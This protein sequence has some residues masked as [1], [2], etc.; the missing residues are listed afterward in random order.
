MGKVKQSRA[1]E[2]S[3]AASP[4]TGDGPEAILREHN[5]A[6][7]LASVAVAFN[8]MW[9]SAY[10]F[11]GR[12][13]WIAQHVGAAIGYTEEGFRSVLQDWTGELIR[14]KDFDV[15]EGSELREF[16]ALLEV[17]VKKT[18][19]YAPS[20]AILYEPGFYL[21]CFR[22]HL[23]LGVK[24]RRVMADEVMPKLVRGEPILPN[25]RLLEAELAEARAQI[26]Q[27]RAA[28]EY[29]FISEKGLEKLKDEIS[30]LVNFMVLHGLA[31]TPGGARFKAIGSYRRIHSGPYDK[32]LSK[33]VGSVFAA[34]NTFRVV[35][36]KEAA[37]K[38][39]ATTQEQLAELERKKQCRLKREQRRQEK[40]ANEAAQIKLIDMAIRSSAVQ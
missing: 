39:V 7:G 37:G 21:V 31:K 3:V 17:R 5:G 16:K 33:N 35:C 15:L 19:T 8:G 1:S 36:E 20:I 22:T 27:L 32:I 2:A 18:L 34:L 28:A 14:G 24:L 10:V 9:V 6:T 40:A 23:P 12:I 4:S 13:C 11:R 38:G 30:D 26:A 25:G 29:E